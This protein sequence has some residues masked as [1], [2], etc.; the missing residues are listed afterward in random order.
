VVVLV[1][2]TI[3]TAG[4]IA[5]MVFG[6]V[7]LVVSV[8][9]YVDQR[10]TKKKADRALDAAAEQSRHAHLDFELR[11]EATSSVMLVVHNLGPHRADQVEVE[12]LLDNGGFNRFARFP[13][14]APLASGARIVPQP[15]YYVIAGNSEFTVRATWEDGAG[16]HEQVEFVATRRIPDE[17][18]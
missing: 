8:F 7:A 3:E 9:T 15:G 5:G 14:I 17:G 11:R 1:E 2:A 16:R 18:I 4:V 12:G 10:S 13:V 6:A